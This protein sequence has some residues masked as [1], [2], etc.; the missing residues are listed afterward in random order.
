MREYLPR[1]VRSSMMN[2]D[3]YRRR[4]T[5]T[6]RL[7]FVWLAV[8]LIGALALVACGAPAGDAPPAT[9]APTAESAAPTS[10]PVTPTLP[11]DPD[12]A[13]SRLTLMLP[14]LYD[15]TASA[16]QAA[17]LSDL[18]SAAVGGPVEVVTDVSRVQAYDALCAGAASAALLH[19]FSAAAAQAQGCGE[20][21]YVLEMDGAAYRTSQIVAPAGE[22]PGVANLPGRVLCRRAAD[23]TAGWGVPVLGLRAAGID[24]FSLLAGVVDA[25]TDEAVLAAVLDGT[26]EAGVV[27]RSAVA[28]LAD[29]AA[30]D[31]VMTF[32]AVPEGV[33]V[34]GSDLEPGTLRALLTV[35]RD[36]RAELAA[37]VGA[38]GL[39]A[40]DAQDIAPLLDLFNAAGVNPAL[41]AQ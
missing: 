12:T 21:V 13:A 23:D 33:L 25:G 15:A 39:L 18:L 20:P 22:V 34:A 17:A 40:A 10:A 8:A 2:W 27:E 16:E 29:P 30:V 14:P 1:P 28:A 31:V 4:S 41:M 3:A 7:H 24:P 37:L 38:D 35:L 32:P 26:C 9:P 11:P 19:P 6:R 36:H 5:I